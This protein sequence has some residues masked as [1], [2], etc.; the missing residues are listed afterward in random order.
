MNA[1]FIGLGNILGNI[2]K[3]GNNLLIQR[4]FGAAP[5]GLYT[6]GMSMATLFVAVFNLGLDDAMVRYVS[7]YKS[8]RQ[9]NLLRGLTL[10]CSILA[11][12]GGMIGGLLMLFLAPSLATLRHAPGVA[13]L[14]V[15]MALLIPL[16]S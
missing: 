13:P 1:T 16:M 12:V 11:G 14:L 4:G 15:L 3:Y 10:F 6:L 5:Y 8:R 2:F 9:G 7:I